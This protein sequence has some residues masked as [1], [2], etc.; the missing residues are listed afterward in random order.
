MLFNSWA[1]GVFFL[2]VI[3]LYLPRNRRWQNGVLL[4]SSYFFYGWWD[5]RFLG[6]LLVSTVVDFMVARRMPKASGRGRRRLLMVSLAANLGILGFFKYFNFFI[7]STVVFLTE[8]GLSA[9]APVLN[10]VLPVGI[11]FYTFQTLAY[12]IDVYRGRIQPTSD[13]VQFAVY[14][15]FFP[16]LVAGPIERAQHLLPQLSSPRRATAHQVRSGAALIFIGLTRKIAIADVAAPVV[17]RAFDDLATAN[18]LVV[19]AG[20]LLFSIQIYADFAG[21]SDIARGTARVLGIDLMINFEHPYFA[22]NIA[23]FWRTWHISLSTWLRDYLY[24]PLGGNRHGRARTYRNLML[25]MLLGGL[26]HGAA[27]TF[28]VWGAIHGVTL[29]IHRWWTETRPGPLTDAPY[30]PRRMISWLSTMFVVIAAWVFFRAPSI[31]E[32]F[33]GIWSAATLRGGL[34]REALQSFALFLSLITLLLVVDVPQMRKRSHTALL[35]WHPVARGF[36]YAAFILIMVAVPSA[37]DIP[38]V[39]FQF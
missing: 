19:I 22:R 34:D 26:W 14:V 35:T 21:Y 13:I 18:G 28:V 30:L 29:S 11:S 32:A 33:D 39:Y 5:W 8:L 37:A 27:W 31:S 23:Q 15:S 1:F 4:V 36:V 24:I 16:Q 2:I 3:A 10:I 9:S 20:V 17:D 7:D 38:F 12:T 25:T 6:L